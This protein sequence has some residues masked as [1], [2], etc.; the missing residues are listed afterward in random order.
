MKHITRTEYF[1]E[2]LNNN[3][4]ILNYYK[5]V[6]I[7]DGYSAVIVRNVHKIKGFNE[8]YV[9][10]NGIFDRVRI[11]E[12]ADGTLYGVIIHG[13]ELMGDTVIIRG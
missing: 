4:V 13:Q 8:F 10:Y 9:K 5:H 3:N 1:K 6:D 11:Y 2:Q 7:F 12:R